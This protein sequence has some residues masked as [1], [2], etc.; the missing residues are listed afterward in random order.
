MFSPRF[1]KALPFLFY[2]LLNPLQLSAIDSESSREAIISAKTKRL[3]KIRKKGKNRVR[4]YLSFGGNYNS[5]QRSR[6]TEFNSRYL[7]HSSKAIYQ[8]DFEHKNRHSNRGSS[9]G[10]TYL[11]KRSEEYDG[12]FSSKF[13]LFDS[14]NY[15]V[16]YHRTIYD[17]MSKFYR[18]QRTAFGFGRIFFGNNLE[19]DTSIG[20]HDVAMTGHKVSF[21]P[22][23][24]LNIRINKK[25]SI[26]QRSYLY[27]DHESMD[28]EI[29]T[30][31]RYK[32]NK[33]I[34]FDIRYNFEQRRYED[35]KKL[36][37]VNEVYRSITFGLVFKLG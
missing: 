20:Y 14:K 12:A 21:I 9:V 10:K 26:N 5:N 36:K 27:I 33:K 24:R 22:S 37:Q 15:G 2:F 18:D 23:I 25:F 7:Y 19:V 1:F 32:I 6:N 8:L 29:R 31:L 17:D 35:D 16:F 4:Q 3:Y 13:L 11:I 28:N 30:S 34:S